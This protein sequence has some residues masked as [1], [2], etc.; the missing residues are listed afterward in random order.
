MDD[1]G[2]TLPFD[3]G[4]AID[5]ALCEALDAAGIDG[6]A[7]SMR[8]EDGPPADAGEWGCPD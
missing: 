1:S 6:D 4:L 3:P 7:P 2:F 8:E 5:T